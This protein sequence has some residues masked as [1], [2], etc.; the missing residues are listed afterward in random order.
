[1]NRAETEKRTV[2]CGMTPCILLQMHPCFIVT[3]T[4]ASNYSGQRHV[5]DRNASRLR[6]SDL[7]A[8][9]SADTACPFYRVRAH[10]SLA[11]TTAKDHPVQYATSSSAWIQLRPEVTHTRRIPDGAVTILPHKRMS[12]DALI[13]S[14]LGN[15]GQDD[16]GMAACRQTA[17]LATLQRLKLIQITVYSRI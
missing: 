3:S 1:M 9:Q 2:L 11:T 4:R 6:S 10:S 17:W 12:V 14:H 5:P 7:T 15:S 16:D 8:G 13:T